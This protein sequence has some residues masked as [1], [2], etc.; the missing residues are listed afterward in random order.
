MDADDLDEALSDLGMSSIHS[1][2]PAEEMADGSSNANIGVVPLV[3]SSA[4]LNQVATNTNVPNG[5][6]AVTI[7]AQGTTN[8]P[9]RHTTQLCGL[10]DNQAAGNLQADEKS[11]AGIQHHQLPQPAVGDTATT[12]MIRFFSR[13]RTTRPVEEAEAYLRE[14]EQAKDYHV[15]IHDIL[16]GGSVA[17]IPYNL[18]DDLVALFES[19]LGQLSLYVQNQDA[20]MNKQLATLAHASQMRRL[21]VAS[22]YAPYEAPTAGARTVPSFNASKTTAPSTGETRGFSSGVPSYPA[23]PPG[24]EDPEPSFV[25]SQPT[26]GSHSADHKTFFAQTPATHH[27]RRGDAGHVTMMPTLTP[28]KSIGHVLSGSTLSPLSQAPTFYAE[29]DKGSCYASAVHLM[30]WSEFAPANFP[31]TLESAKRMSKYEADRGL[32]TAA[33]QLIESFSQPA[34]YASRNRNRLIEFVAKAFLL[35]A[36]HLVASEEPS[37]MASAL[38]ALDVSEVNSIYSDTS[39]VID[40]LLT[41]VLAD[42]KGMS[43]SSISSLQTARAAFVSFTQSPMVRLHNMVT[44]LDQLLM[45]RNMA[46]G[47]V[48]AFWCLKPTVEETP[49]TYFDR[50]QQEAALRGISD[51]DL[52]AR[53]QMELVEAPDRRFASLNDM[54]E[55]VSRGGEVTARSMRQHLSGLS[56]AK[57]P[58][59][60]RSAPRAPRAPIGAAAPPAMVAAAFRPTVDLAKVYPILYPDAPVPT[61]GQLAGS[62]CAACATD[63]SWVTT[64]LSFDQHPEFQGTDA[65]GKSKLPRDTGWK[66]NPARCNCLHKRL[67]GLISTDPGMAYLMNPVQRG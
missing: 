46:K 27:A 15:A 49:V 40:D 37:A 45:H 21:S 50:L 38:A 42:S 3:A 39:T 57:S 65:G 48:T 60:V 53:F 34:T 22:G 4:N 31:M 24:M 51:D 19:Q 62:E 66:H 64:W 52:C 1:S 5:S 33:A 29:P 54:L 56:D 8:P 32:T 26:F 44:D 2:P 59:L 10:T 47:I 14:R 61:P 23:D 20:Q 16:S 17:G 35:R 9:A 41:V 30:P 18:T 58:F 12:Y 28:R 7:V 36:Y 11:Q 55:I 25:P 67:A 13:L 43:A 63:R 6:A